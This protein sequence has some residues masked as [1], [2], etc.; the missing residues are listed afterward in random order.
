MYLSNN[1]DVTT[2]EEILRQEIQ[3]LNDLQKKQKNKIRGAILYENLIPPLIH[4][5]KHGDGYQTKNV[6]FD[7]PPEKPK[8]G[9]SMPGYIE[10]NEMIENEP[11]IDITLNDFV[12]FLCTCY[13]GTLY[14]D[15]AKRIIEAL[16]KNDV[17]KFPLRFRCAHTLFAYG[18]PDYQNLCLISGMIYMGIP[19]EGYF[20][21]TNVLV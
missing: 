15:E 10:L 20:D 11:V 12:K 1:A 13:G 4:F 18:S 3:N 19:I 17:K 21:G 9:S 8:K 6:M 16:K 5:I 7:M 14:Q 2:N